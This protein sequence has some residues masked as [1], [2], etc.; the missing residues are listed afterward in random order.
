LIF[1]H[2]RSALTTREPTWIS[3]VHG[4]RQLRHAF[5]NRE[6]RGDGDVVVTRACFATFSTARAPHDLKPAEL[7]PQFRHVRKFNLPGEHLRAQRRVDSD[8]APTQRRNLLQNYSGC[9]QTLLHN[10][11]RDYRSRSILLARSSEYRKMKYL[12]LARSAYL[13]I[14]RNH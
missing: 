2:Q 6:C 7:R 9:R 10:F 4:T 11:V 8:C 12:G 5:V 3:S 14:W 13:L 1:V